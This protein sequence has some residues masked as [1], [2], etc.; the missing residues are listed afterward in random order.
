MPKEDL[1][2]NEKVFIAVV[3]DSKDIDVISEIASDP[4]YN[5][6]AGVICGKVNIAQ[7]QSN[8]SDHK[9]T[10]MA[11][12]F[13]KN[14]LDAKPSKDD[15]NSMNSITR[16]E[17]NSELSSIEARMDAR[18]EK[19]S[20][21]MQQ[22]ISELRVERADR[23]TQVMTAIAEV[24][25]RLEP[26]KGIR[27]TVIVTAVTGV[28]TIAGV[29]LAAMSIYATSFDSGRNTANEIQGVRQELIEKQNNTD[30]SLKEISQSLK[31]LSSAIKASTNKAE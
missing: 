4:S 10:S 18:V 8:I 20:S 9:I 22:V 29:I 7:S 21:S 5:R 16:H 25:G 30:Q 28:I 14:K 31:E 2:I 1:T 26:L 3:Q 6:V 19:L 12:A 13:K 11:T 15:P 23:D 17:F 27:S 24:N